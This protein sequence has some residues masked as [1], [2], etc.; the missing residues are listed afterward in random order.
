MYEAQRTTRCASSP[1]PLRTPPFAPP[2][3]ATVAATLNW[4]HCSA[5][6]WEHRRGDRNKKKPP[7]GAQKSDRGGSF[8]RGRGG[9]AHRG[10]LEAKARVRASV[11]GDLD[12][13]HRVGGLQ[14][15]LAAALLW[16]A[17]RAVRS[18]AK[19]RATHRKDRHS[20]ENRSLPLAVLTA[21]PKAATT[22][23]RSASA[24]P[25]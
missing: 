23:A 11:A 2:A 7:V 18:A 10:Q 5:Q 19:S 12:A 8:R 24:S 21:A 14:S 1:R 9:A 22:R 13:H 15:Y 6:E 4:K 25:R 20:S 16:V 17:P 3:A